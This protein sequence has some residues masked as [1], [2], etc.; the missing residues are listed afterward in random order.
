MNIPKNY[1]MGTTC[2]DKLKIKE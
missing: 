2:C 1:H